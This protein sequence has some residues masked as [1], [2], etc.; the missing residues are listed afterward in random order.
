MRARSTQDAGPDMDSDLS[1]RRGRKPKGKT[2]E[3]LRLYIN[4]HPR[5][6]RDDALPPT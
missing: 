4:V 6:L 5:M 3:E 2:N 1:K